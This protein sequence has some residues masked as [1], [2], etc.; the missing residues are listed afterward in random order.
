MNRPLFGAGLIVALP[1]LGTGAVQ[2]LAFAPEDG[3]AL[4]VVYVMTSESELVAVAI[5]IEGEEQ[6]VPAIEEGPRVSLTNRI[7]VADDYEELEGDR[8]TLLRRRFDELSRTRTVSPPDGEEVEV[9]QASDLEG[10]TVVFAWDED[11]GE[12]EVTDEDDEL[13]ESLLAGLREDMSLRTFLPEDEVEEGDSWEVDLDAYANVMWPGGELGF[14]D[15]DADERDA[16]REELS[17][18]MRAALEGEVTATFEGFEEV[19]GVRVAVIAI[20]VEAT[21]EAAV[22]AELPDGREERRGYEIE[23]SPEGRLLWNV[24]ANRAHSLEMSGDASET[25]STEGV[26][27]TQDAEFSF[28]RRHFFE[29]TI[30]Y[31]A[32]FTDEDSEESE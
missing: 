4:T 18:G 6:E 3:T 16:D 1:L 20:A 26:L 17:A 21:S 30:T 29:G 23:R 10:H 5:E 25:V 19:D 9:R 12:Y 22:D 11:E 27:A 24:E 15:E 28:V 2:D 14:R 8:P 13:D 7:V 32:S 31:E